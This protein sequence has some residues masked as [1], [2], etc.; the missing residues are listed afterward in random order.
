MSQKSS[1]FVRET[2]ETETWLAPGTGSAGEVSVGESREEREQ[3][4]ATAAL[5]R[6]ALTAIPVP[7]DAEERSR[8]MAVELLKDMSLNRSS[9]TQ[10]QAPWYLRLGHFLRYVFTFG[11]RR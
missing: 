7:E 8:A 3:L 11:R 6:G 2:R 5:A 1:T 10:F 9:R 4:L